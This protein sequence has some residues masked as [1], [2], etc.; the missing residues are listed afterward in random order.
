MMSKMLVPLLPELEQRALL[1]GDLAGQK[2]LEERLAG[3]QHVGVLHH[4]VVPE[5]TRNK[6]QRNQLQRPKRGTNQHDVVDTSAQ[7]R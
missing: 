2:G 4:F 6:S 5:E 1:L 3:G 7:N